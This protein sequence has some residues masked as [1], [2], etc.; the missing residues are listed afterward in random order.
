[1]YTSWRYGAHMETSETTQWGP[2][3]ARWDCAMH[4]GP[5]NAC[6]T[7]KALR[8]VAK[9]LVLHFRAFS[10][11]FAHLAQNLR[12]KQTCIFAPFRA[13]SRFFA[14]F[15]RFFLVVFFRFAFRRPSA[16]AS[17]NFVNNLSLY[18]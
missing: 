12:P 16:D 2:Y 17:Q 7:P 8:S 4:Y 5:L 6:C 1:M 3:V 14:H 15:A 11:F 18:L 9:T 10:R 13:F